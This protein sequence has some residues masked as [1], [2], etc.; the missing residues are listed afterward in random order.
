MS[1]CL[2]AAFAAHFTKLT[3]EFGAYVINLIVLFVHSILLSILMLCQFLSLA[4]S[5]ISYESS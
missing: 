3:C 2:F 5:A 4:F 1:N